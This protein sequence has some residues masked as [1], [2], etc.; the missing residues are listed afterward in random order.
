[1]SNEVAEPWKSMTNRILLAIA[2]DGLVARLDMDLMADK[3]SVN[4]MSSLEI[5]YEGCWKP[6]S[7]GGT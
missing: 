4:I 2:G 1:M 3:M 7:R 6:I 5:T